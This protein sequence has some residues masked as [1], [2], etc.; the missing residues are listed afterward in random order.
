MKTAIVTGAGSGIGKATAKRLVAD[1]WGVTLNGRTESK[2]TGLC[3]ELGAGD[4]VKVFSGDVGDRESVADLIAFH[5]KEFSGLD[6][7]VNNA[8]IA[9]GGKI[10]EIDP[11]EWSKLMRINVDGVFHTCALAK[12]ALVA[13]GGAIVNVSSVSGIGGDWGFS[14]Y[15]ASKGAVSNFTRSLALELAEQGV[16]VNAVAPSLT[17]TPMAE[18]VTSNEEVMK[19]FR[20][21]L[22]MRRAAQPSEVASVIAFLLSEDASFVNGVVLP[23]DGGLSASNGQPEL[24]GLT[25]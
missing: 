12:K 19:D 16:R 24:G 20:K 8:A 23:V 9:S 1:G 10:E 4:K 22:P 2:L 3:N 25:S 21:R 18:D 7:L 5:L 13:S 6:A 17:E 14:P 15:N 11:E